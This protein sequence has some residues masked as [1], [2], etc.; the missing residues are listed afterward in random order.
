MRADAVR[1]DAVIVRSPGL[2]R[3]RSWD[4]RAHLPRARALARRR[5]HLITILTR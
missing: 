2:G 5:C 3:I 4:F 1:A